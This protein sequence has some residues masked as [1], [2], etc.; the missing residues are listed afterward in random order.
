MITEANVSFLS[1][2]CDNLS[3]PVAVEYMTKAGK[4]GPEVLD[5]LTR[6]V[7]VIQCCKNV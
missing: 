3:M 4:T 7:D 5:M 1:A 2:L 6:H